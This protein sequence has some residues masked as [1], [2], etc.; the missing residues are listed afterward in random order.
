MRC[1]SIHLTDLC[2]SR[3]SFCVVGSPHY[4]Q[5]SIKL[6][7]VEQFLTSHAG[8]GWD[9]LNLHGGEATIHKHFIDILELARTLK[10]P[11]V[12][13]QTN[14]IRLADRAFA[15]TVANLGVT[16]G[17]V[18]LHG[19]TAE[20]QD[21]LTGTRGGFSRTISGIQN[22]RKLGVAVRTNTVI[23]SSNVHELEHIAEVACDLDVGHVNISN[24]H[25]VG[26]ATFSFENS[27]VSFCDVRPRL[28]ASI[29][30]VKARGKVI[31]LEGFPY[32]TIPEHEDLH[33]NEQGRQI[34]MLMRGLVIDDYDQF[35][36]TTCRRYGDVCEPCKVRSRCGGVYPE[37]L[38]R[39]GWS[40]FHAY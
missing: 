6:S 11:E 28:L 23:L 22:L 12:H 25:P 5:D 30:L 27:A 33:L 26:S 20:L 40:E 13:L 2:N 32:C 14:A 35:M 39:R 1:L 17:I 9:V 8:K 21:A 29:E 38:A 37:Y 7:D 10:Y 16:L 31:T 19:H 18:S 36:N 24:L 3:C 34:K 4:A 15:E